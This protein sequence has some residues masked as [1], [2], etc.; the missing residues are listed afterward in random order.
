MT[1]LQSPPTSSPPRRRGRAATV[2]VLI[3]SLLASAATR[4][5]ADVLRDQ[6]I[7]HRGESASG[8]SLSSMNSFALGLLLGGL[9]GPLVMALWTQSESQKSDKNLEGFDTQIEWIRLLQPEFDTVHIF[10]I[11]NKAYN[12]SVQMASLANKYVVILDAL[13]YAHSVDREKPDDINILAAIATIDFDKFGNSTEKT[14]YRRRVRAESLPHPTAAKRA[15]DPGW[16]RTSLDPMLDDNFN[17]LPDLLRPTVGHDRPANLAPN[18]EFN[19]GS[20]LQYLAAWQPFPDGIS[21]FALAFNYWKRCEV[22]QNVGNQRHDQ[23]SDVVIDS[24]PALSLKNWLEEEWEQGRRREAQAF[25][26]PVPEDRMALEQLTADFLPNHPIEDRHAADLAEFAYTRAAALLPAALAEYVRDISKNPSSEGIYRS[27]IDEIRA[28]AEMASADA[29][30]L[31]AQLAPADQRKVLLA[32]AK[33]RYDR[34]AFLDSLN[35]LKYYTDDQYLKTAM[36]KGYDRIKTPDHPG[37]EDFTPEQM[38]QTLTAVNKARANHPDS[39][40]EDMKEFEIYLNRAIT[41][42]KILTSTP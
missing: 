29:A 41:R 23:L 42:I 1:Q 38:V 35:I 19:D 34:T 36:P 18:Q 21:P 13:D 40:D 17:I 14:Y 11:W 25:N 26:L 3:L 39:H 12:I 5:W 37:I 9:R 30:Y 8:T 24:R 6:D 7:P 10:Q 31:A 20:E 27:H 2:A 4:Y 33:Q 15:N 16:R 28:A 32:A 22:L